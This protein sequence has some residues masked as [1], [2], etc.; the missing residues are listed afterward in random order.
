MSYS[1]SYSASIPFSGSVSYS[2]P[3]SDTGGS[4]TAH[5]SGSVPVNV[6]INV[7]T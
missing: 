1:R 7:N 6:T 5:Y 3:K 2:Y 4:G